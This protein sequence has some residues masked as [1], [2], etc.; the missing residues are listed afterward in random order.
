MRA[1]SF[2][3][4]LFFLLRWPNTV[5]A[6]ALADAIQHAHKDYENKRCNSDPFI[7]S[8]SAMFA[9][10]EPSDSCTVVQSMCSCSEN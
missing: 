5:F 7:C 9:I 2:F 10:F 4:C 3:Q 8:M 6:H 1:F